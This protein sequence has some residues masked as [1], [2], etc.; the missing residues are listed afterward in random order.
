MLFPIARV[1]VACTLLASVQA[2]SA[3][4]IPTDQPVSA[5]LNTAQA[6]LRNGET[7]EALLYYDAAIA[8]D[9]ADYLTLFKR[10]TTFLSLGRVSQATDDLNKVLNLKPGFEGA[11]LQLAKLRARTGDWSG[12]KSQFSSAG[13]D[14]SDAEVVKLTEAQRAAE[15]AEAASQTGDWEACVQQASV[16]IAVAP[17]AVN[18]REIR[19]RC[20]F[21]RAELEEGMGDLQHVLHLRAG[22]TGPH[23]VISATTFYSLGDMDSG[24]AQIRKCLHSDPDS[25]VCK[26]VHKQQKAVQKSLGKIEGLVNKGLQTSA[27]KALVGTD[28]EVGLLT[29]IRE[30]I[31]E[32]QQSG[33]LPPTSRSRLYQT[34]VELACQVHMESTHRDAD[35]FCT[36]SLQNDSESFWGLLHR[37]KTLLKDED[38]EASINTLEKAAEVDPNRRDKVNPILQKAKVALKRSKSKDYYKVL[39]VAQDADEK[40]IKSAYRKATKLYHPDKAVNQGISREDA[41][42]KMA[43][44]NEAYEV[45]SD[46]ELR[47][48]F[49]RGDDPNS[50]ESNNP[51]QG[52]PFGPGGHPFMYQQGGGGGGPHGNRFKFNFNGGGPFGF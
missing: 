17:R 4:D 45:L 21:E 30:Q 15:Q 50:H 2:L 5:L 24:L 31:D 47:A 37:G 38:F 46:P 25:K 12:A 18:L 43:S 29:M 49:D 41:E 40:Q 27:R 20:R 1:A 48:R 52:S 19:S 3:Q 32:L 44:I 10:A 28:E 16:A 51:F 22:D 33:G 39:D 13:K 35:K 6:H 8:K 7:S 36:E 23:V 14:K 26:K 11:H 9:P 34:V 42:K